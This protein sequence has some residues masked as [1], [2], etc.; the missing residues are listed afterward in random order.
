MD[1]NMFLEGMN[2]PGNLNEEYLEGLLRLKKQ[3]PFCAT[4]HLLLL[5]TLK[6][7]DHTDYIK[8]TKAASPFVHDRKHGY[9]WLQEQHENVEV[10][11]KNVDEK[12]RNGM[13]ELEKEVHYQAALRKSEKE[14]DYQEAQPS[15]RENKKEHQNK[16]ESPASQLIERFV[17]QQ[18]AI[19]PDKNKSYEKEEKWADSSIKDS[20]GM[21]T[22]TL[23]KIYEGQGK[24]K[25]A[26]QVYEK[27]NLNFP[28]KGDY[29]ATRINELENKLGSE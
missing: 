22:E 19:K 9:K 10:E 12:D 25:K 8:E 13:T 28:E 21:V 18:P 16:Q 14:Q 5:K 27:L 15:A 23:A 20:S 7:L 3:Y 24:I 29:F 2:Y 26:I 11:R 6:N 17:Q 4:I 1:H